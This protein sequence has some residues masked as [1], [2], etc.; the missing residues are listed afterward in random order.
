MTEIAI[1]RFSSGILLEHLIWIPDA[2]DSFRDPMRRNL[3]CR[4]LIQI[5][6]HN[7]GTFR[8]SNCCLFVTVVVVYT[9]NQEQIRAFFFSSFFRG[10]SFFRRGLRPVGKRGG[11]VAVAAPKICREKET[12]ARKRKREERRRKRERRKRKERERRARGKDVLWV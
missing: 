3:Q 2:S 6:L 8:P 12:K 11:M 4:A 5:C 7:K 9:Y 10:Y 1:R